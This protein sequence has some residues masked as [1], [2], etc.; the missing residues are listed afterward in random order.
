MVDGLSIRRATLGGF[1]DLARVR[2]LVF[3]PM[4]FQ[5]TAQPHAGDQ[6][7][8]ACIREAGSQRG[9]CGWLAATVSGVA[10]ARSG[11]AMDQHTTGPSSHCGRTLYVTSAASAPPSGRRVVGREPMRRPPTWLQEQGVALAELHTTDMGRPLHEAL[12]LA[13]SHAMR[14]ALPA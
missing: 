3:E 1:E 14:L 6:T 9:L 5:Y 2:R 12:G 7:T 11:L 8:A 10:V 4:G 13:D